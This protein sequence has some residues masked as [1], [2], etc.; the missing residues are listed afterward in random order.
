[1][2]LA[3]KPDLLKKIL[4][5]AKAP[6]RDAAAVN[7]TRW[8]LYEQLKTL[9]FPIECGSGGVT[10]F[11]RT[12]RGLPKAHWIDAACVGKSTPDV[13]QAHGVVPLLIIANGSG[14]RQMC[15]TDKYGFPVRHRTRQ[16]RHHGFQTG[17]M[18]RVGVPSGK[19]QGVY[20]G[21]VLVRATGSFD[22]R[23][24]QERVQGISHRYCTPLYRGDGY[25][26]Q[27]GEAAIP[28]HE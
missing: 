27:I 16:K 9:D 20:T 17:D 24:K 4:A 8:I 3:K 28:H 26:Y 12:T 5:Q 14:N 13:L 2:F 18:V 23:T 15:G 19:K 10:K 22:I 6:L 11:N 21:R 7:T 25:R 1:V